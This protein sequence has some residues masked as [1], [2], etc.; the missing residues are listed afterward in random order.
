MMGNWEDVFRDWAKP[1]GKTEQ[2]RCA[3]ESEL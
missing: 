2:D 3:K 1:P